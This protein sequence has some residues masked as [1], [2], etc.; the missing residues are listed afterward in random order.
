MLHGCLHYVLLSQLNVSIGL[1]ESCK[2]AKIELF[3]AL[4]GSTGF[5]RSFDGA[6]NPCA[7]C[8]KRRFVTVLKKN[9]WIQFHNNTFQ[10]I[11]IQFQTNKYNYKNILF[12]FSSSYQLF[13]LSNTNSKI[14]DS[15][16]VSS[17]SKCI[18]ILCWNRRLEFSTLHLQSVTV[19]SVT[20]IFPLIYCARHLILYQYRHMPKVPVSHVTTSSGWPQFH[21]SIMDWC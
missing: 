19:I 4:N 8:W 15:Y 9:K 1:Q 21:S 14:S 2:P 16:S 7:D 17:V 10:F 3:R 6:Q 5:W 18:N 11:G 20:D 12:R 13:I